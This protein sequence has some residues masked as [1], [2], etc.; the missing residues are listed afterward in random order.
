MAS[1]VTQKI[2][3]WNLGIFEGP[4]GKHNEWKPFLGGRY[5]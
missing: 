3:Q 1:F 2:K 4:V 5:K